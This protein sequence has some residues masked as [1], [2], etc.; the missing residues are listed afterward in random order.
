MHLLEQIKNT[1]ELKIDSLED[2]WFLSQFIAPEDTIFA[3]DERKVKIGDG[4]TKQVKKLI[5][6]DLKVKKINFDSEVLRLNGEILN[7]TEFTAVGQSHSLSF[8]V[9]SI[10]KIE[11]KS[12]L[13]YEK[14]LLDNAIKSKKTKNILILLD[15]DELIATEFTNSNF[16]VLFEKSG[17]GSKK[18]YH[19][20][21][22]EEE[23]KF[24][25]IKEFIERGY[26][27]IIFA[28]PA[29]FKDRLFKYTNDKINSKIKIISFN[30]P[31][32]NTSAV[33]RAIKDIYKQNILQSTQLSVEND[34]M[35]ELLKNIDK[36]SKHAYGI[37]NV[38]DSINS[39]SCEKLLVSNKLIQ[40]KRE[41]DTYEELNTL[42]K[43][44]E[45]INS[46]LHIINSKNETGKVL[47][48]LGKIAAILRY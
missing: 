45:S 38:M 44:A 9:N 22:N 26:E 6:I 43:T 11:K 17:L 41:D 20:E 46:E 29:H 4:N 33:E 18:Q 8:L 35:S 14:E 3:L 48:G 47:D 36:G 19:N 37:K 40:E 15:K 28:G 7:Q 31:D 39:G 27:N 24:N 12:L 42:M 32:V 34:L 2:L 16:S 30:F 1:F 25:L 5:R 21:I 10:I 23:E 13:K